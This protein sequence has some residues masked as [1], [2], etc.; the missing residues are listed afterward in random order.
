MTPHRHLRPVPETTEPPQPRPWDRNPH[1]TEKSWEAFV[2]YRDAGVNRTFQRVADTLRK[3][4]ALIRRWSGL[5]DWEARVLAYER[6]LDQGR[7]NTIANS[8]GE[9]A[10]REAQLS[11]QVQAVALRALATMD[12]STLS[13]QD[14]AAFLKVSVAIERQVYFPKEVGDITANI[15]ATILIDPVLVTP[16]TRQPVGHVEGQGHALEG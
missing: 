1:D 14:V 2:I 3:S 6:W 7:Q 15:A 13:P 9:V 10:E 5:H 11:R 12:A 8:R 4:G 16:Q